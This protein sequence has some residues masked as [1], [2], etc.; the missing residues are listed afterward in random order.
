MSA[1]QAMETEVTPGDTLVTFASRR[2]T[3][4]QHSSDSQEGTFDQEVEPTAEPDLTTGTTVAS[5]S[6]E[7][8]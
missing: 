5:T 6:Q 3:K 1:D 4:R 2:S 7:E 8:I